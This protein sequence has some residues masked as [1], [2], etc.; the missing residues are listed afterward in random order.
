[1][2][3]LVAVG[4]WLARAEWSLKRPIA[5]VTRRRLGPRDRCTDVDS[6]R[7]IGVSGR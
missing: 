2:V 1:M 3:V 4:V 7:H 5:E 6:H